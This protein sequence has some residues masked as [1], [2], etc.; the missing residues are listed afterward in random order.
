MGYRDTP[1]QRNLGTPDPIV[2][3]GAIQFSLDIRHTTS[4]DLQSID[5]LIDRI[6]QVQNTKKFMVRLCYAKRFVSAEP[7]YARALQT[8]VGATGCAPSRT[9]AWWGDDLDTDPAG[10]CTEEQY[11][12][13]LRDTGEY[14]LWNMMFTAGVA[15]HAWFPRFTQ[16]TAEFIYNQIGDSFFLKSLSLG[17]HSK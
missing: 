6:R 14:F 13:C 5:L 10:L 4:R 17:K 7:E 9:D 16:K 2:S 12:Q 3:R 15:T 11:R 1:F 8:I